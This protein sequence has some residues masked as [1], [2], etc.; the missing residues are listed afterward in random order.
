MKEQ[1]TL[2]KLFELRDYLEENQIKPITVKGKKYYHLSD[3][4]GSL[5]VETGSSLLI[6]TK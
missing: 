4:R 2:K 3:I 5:L 6:E 1:L